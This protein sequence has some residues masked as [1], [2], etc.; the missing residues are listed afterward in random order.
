MSHPVTHPDRSFEVGAQ[1]ARRKQP[2]E[3][4]LL[5]NTSAKKCQAHHSCQRCDE[6]EQPRVEARQS[7]CEGASKPSGADAEGR[8]ER[9]GRSERTRCPAPARRTGFVKPSKPDCLASTSNKLTT[10]SPI[11]PKRNL[12]KP[13]KNIA[14]PATQEH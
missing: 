12:Q 6:L 14:I 9:A 5:T 3:I 4:F 11:T 1:G 7:G 2:R 13:T 10:L 8:P